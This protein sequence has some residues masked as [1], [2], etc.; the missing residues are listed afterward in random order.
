MIKLDGFR[1]CIAT[2][3]GIQLVY[4]VI[5]IIFEGSF[6]FAQVLCYFIMLDL[7]L[8]IVAV[9][10]VMGRVMISASPSKALLP[11]AE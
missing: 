3:L 2:Y 8:G 5:T 4:S 6:A 9:L 10:L 1:I 7:F 11:V